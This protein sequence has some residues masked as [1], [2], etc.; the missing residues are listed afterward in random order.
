MSKPTVSFAA[1]IESP[2]GNEVL[3]EIGAWAKVYQ[4]EFKGLVAVPSDEYRE[5]RV[6]PEGL[7]DI[8]SIELIE[9]KLGN[10]QPHVIIIRER[11]F[12]IEW[13]T[14]KT[15]DDIRTAYFENDKYLVLKERLVL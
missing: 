14:D 2:G 9:L 5:N 15:I 12:T 1:S 7:V 10:N 11:E 13:S 4:G 8:Q 6:L 3:I